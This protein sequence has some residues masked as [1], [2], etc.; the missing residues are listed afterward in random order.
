VGSDL[1]NA[2]GFYKEPVADKAGRYRAVVRRSS[3]NGGD[4]V[5][6]RAASAV[7]RH[8]H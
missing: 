8:R 6:R 1:T 4:D 7:K 2:N 5:C 3:P